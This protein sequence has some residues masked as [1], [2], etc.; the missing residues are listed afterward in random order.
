MNFG[1][2]DELIMLKDTVRTFAEE[3]IRPFAD[4]WDENHYFPYEEVVKPMGEL[5]FFGTIIPEE[6]GGNE[7]GWLAA[8]IITEEIA[9]VSSSLRVQINMQEIGSAYTILRYGSED[10]KKKYIPKLVRAEIL[11]AFAIT[12]PEA[13][14]DV[15]AIKSTARDKGD[16]WLVNGQKTWISNASIGGINIFYAYTDRSLG[17]KGLSAFVIELE[18]FNDI[19]V[20][21]L[22]KMGSRSSPTGEIILTDTRVPKENIL[23]NPGD[24]ARIVFGS[25]AQTRLSAAAGGVGLAQACLDT[26]TTYA[27][28]RHQFGKPIGEFQMNQSLIAEMVAEIEAARLVVYKAAWQK[29]Q[30]ILNNNKEV[31]QAKYLAGELAYKC[32]QY[33]MRILG[34][35]GY[36]T[37]YP[38]ARYFRDAPTY[39]MVEGSANICKFII[40]QD[41]LG[42][43]SANR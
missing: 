6:Y 30:G 35:Y 43:R 38:V 29:D 22:D 34:A 42:I 12:E 33:A 17:G 18:N 40:A 1:L 15:M 36:S 25:L 39:A 21:D 7:M 20:T 2:S 16:Y 41:Q 32:S 23:G 28:E 9:R 14:S 27:M 31:A 13:G 19:T 11:G 4:E 26:V 5:G 3:K 10:L 24:G 8:M 37:E